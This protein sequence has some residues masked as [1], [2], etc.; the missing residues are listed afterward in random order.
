MSVSLK[1]R[2]YRHVRSRIV[3]GIL[4]AGS[5]ISYRKL[6]KEVGVSCMP[7]REAIR[8]LVAEGLVESHSRRGTF[9]STPS[10]K[11]LAE[12]YDLRVAI[13]KHAAA[14]LAGRMSPVDLRE[15]R[16]QNER[17]REIVEEVRATKGLLWVSKEARTWLKCDKAIHLTLLCA[18]GN[19]RAL[20]TVQNMHLPHVT[21]QLDLMPTI[22]GLEYAVDS[23]E[24]L[25][26]AIE[27]GDGQQASEIVAQ[28]IQHAYEHTM[29]A[30]AE[31]HW[32]EIKGWDDHENKL[33]E[34]VAKRI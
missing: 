16:K 8:E 1:D 5:S 32:G 22:E 26:K 19:E 2:V 33:P 29:K 23:H 13:E 28:H 15:V 7:V 30:L 21:G 31:G 12:A 6:A 3:E 4:P 11:D 27:E 17:L 24:K 14:K 25:F 9:V 10:H 20:R 34:S 18:A